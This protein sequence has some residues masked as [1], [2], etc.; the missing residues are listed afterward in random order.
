VRENSTSGIIATTSILL[1]VISSCWETH[2]STIVATNHYTPVNRSFICLMETMNVPR[3]GWKVTRSRI[4]INRMEII[5]TGSAT[6][7]HMP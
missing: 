5:Y 6:K 3:Q 2:Y 1:N 7:I 4:P